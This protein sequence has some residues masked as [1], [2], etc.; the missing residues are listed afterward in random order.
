MEDQ[1]IQGLKGACINHCLGLIIIPG[2]DVADRAK[3]RHRYCHIRV[4]Q[5][6]HE[7]WQNACMKD[8]RDAI[9][10]AI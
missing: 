10:S 2:N 5:K 8:N 3:A 6:L 4:L 7:P 9:F 1:L